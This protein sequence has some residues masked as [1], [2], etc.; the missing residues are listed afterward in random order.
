VWAVDHWGWQGPNL[1]ADVSRWNSPT[2]AGDAYQAFSAN[3]APELAA[4]VVVAVPLRSSDAALWLAQMGVTASMV[5]LD[6]GHDKHDVWLD[7]VAYAPLLEPGGILCGH[8]YSPE[9]PGVVE[10]VD[11]LT[12]GAQVVPGTSIWWVVK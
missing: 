6:A 5:F 11:L 10:A 8:D 2:N 9:F 3:L 12:D 7:V 1:G 4:G